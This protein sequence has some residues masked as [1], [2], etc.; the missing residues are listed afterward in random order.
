MKRD[1]ETNEKRERRENIAYS[2]NNILSIK[3]GSG[4]IELL[5]VCIF[6]GLLA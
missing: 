5:G 2:T 4:T 6:P 3:A 1:Q